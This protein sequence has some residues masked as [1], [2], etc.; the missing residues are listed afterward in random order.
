M[1]EYQDIHT[2]NR[3]KTANYTHKV[4]SFVRWSDSEKLII[5][6]NF[7]QENGQDFSLEIPENVISKWELEDGNYAVKDVTESQ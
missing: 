6:S 2:Y 5:V 4:Y 7:D 1:G 3:S